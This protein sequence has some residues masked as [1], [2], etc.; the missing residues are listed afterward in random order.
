MRKTRE[1]QE[2]A[3]SLLCANSGG[4]VMDA[5]RDEEDITAHHDLLTS[6]TEN[7]RQSKVKIYHI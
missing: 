5:G 4:R 3:A 1:E 7:S 2:R 6:T